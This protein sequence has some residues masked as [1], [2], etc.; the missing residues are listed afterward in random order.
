[1][2]MPADK[3]LNTT[4]LAFL[5]DAV[6]EVRVRERVIKSGQTNADVLHGM[7]VQY[8]NAKA[9]AKTLKMIRNELSEDERDLVRRARNRKP[10]TKPKNVGFVEY[11]QA[12]A[13]EAL[14]G[15]LYLARDEERLNEIL[16]LAFEANL[17]GDGK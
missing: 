17:N 13:F 10:G 3:Q 11:K 5:G 16:N 14:I 6:Y 9:Q 7:A 15:H 4:A 8:V 2:S 1:M 12:T